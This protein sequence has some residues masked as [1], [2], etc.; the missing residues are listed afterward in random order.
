[1]RG[2]IL[3]MKS[4]TQLVFDPIKLFFMFAM[5]RV[6]SLGFS[7]ESLIRGAWIVD[8]AM[9]FWNADRYVS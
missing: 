8:S 1:M 5:I 4:C 7:R 3:H 9:S 6:G 2:D